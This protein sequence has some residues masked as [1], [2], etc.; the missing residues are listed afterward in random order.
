MR[1]LVGTVIRACNTPEAG[2]FLRRQIRVRMTGRLLS[3]RRLQVVKRDSRGTRH[4]TV[5]IVGNAVI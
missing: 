4:R 3:N 1:G 5:L 2:E